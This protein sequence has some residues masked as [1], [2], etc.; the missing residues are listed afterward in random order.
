MNALANLLVFVVKS[1][2][3]SWDSFGACSGRPVTP[4][5]L[6]WALGKACGSL[7]TPSGLAWVVLGLPWGSLGTPGHPL[8]GPWDRKLRKNNKFL[9]FFKKMVL[10]LE[11]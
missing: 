6:P 8:G 4:L 11:F 9:S 7:G 1:L 5:G 2:W 3:V 10:A